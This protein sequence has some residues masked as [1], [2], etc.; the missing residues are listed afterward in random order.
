MS[1][2]TAGCSSRRSDAV[3]C[4]WAGA[5]S[6]NSVARSNLW[7][8]LTNGLWVSDGWL[9]TGTNSPLRGVASCPQPR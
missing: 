5:E 4:R 3:T 1:C 7:Y 6:N 8:R 9:D 2:A